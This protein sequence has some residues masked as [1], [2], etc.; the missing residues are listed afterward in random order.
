[1]A[2]GISDP[3]KCTSTYREKDPPLDTNIIAGLFAS[4]QVGPSGDSRVNFDSIAQPNSDMTS[5]DGTRTPPSDAKP[6][7]VPTE[8][9]ETGLPGRGGPVTAAGLPKG[10]Q[11]PVT[12]NSIGMKLALIPGASSSRCGSPDANAPPEEL[13]EHK[14]RITTPFLLGVTEVT[15]AQ[16]EG[17]IG[18]NPSFFS[19]TGEG[20]DI[21]AGQPTGEYP[22]E[23]VSWLDAIAFCNAFSKKEGLAPYYLVN[24]ED[25]KIPNRKGPGYRL[26]T[27]AEWEYACRAGKSGKFPP[28]D[29]MIEYG[30]FR[31]NSNGSTHPVGKKRPNEF[32]LFDMHANVFEWCFDGFAFDYY[33]RSPADDPQGPDGMSTRVARGSGWRSPQRKTW[34]TRFEGR[35]PHQ[36]HF[37]VGFRVARTQSAIAVSDKL[38][39]PDAAAATSAKSLVGQAPSASVDKT[40]INEPLVAT[41]IHP[42]AT[43][44]VKGSPEEKLATRGLARS[45]A[46]FVVASEA[47]ILEKFQKIKPLIAGLAQ[48]FNAFAVALRNE[49]LLADA[50]AYYTDIKERVDAAYDFV[51][52]MPNGSRASSQDKQ[53]YQ[54]AQMA[55]NELVQERDDSSK[56]VDAMRTQQV[57][58]VRKEELIK[59]FNAKWSEFRKAADELMPLIDKALGEYRKLH[60]DSTVRDALA[61]LSRSTKAAAILGPSKNLQ[62]SIDTIKNARRTYSPETAAPKKKARSSG[63]SPAAAQKRKGQATKQ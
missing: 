36:R 35:D 27:E 43:P 56:V 42:L 21:V 8:T 50:E 40:Q 28:G 30:W 58:A 38:S 29:P 18:K 63:A 32:G 13:P 22:V 33:Q 62:N 52:K 14:V 44:F 47:E 49:W 5:D 61:T 12:E 53:E 10:R 60:G 45:G 25:V 16:Y 39:L 15:Q 4:R 7:R 24:G 6:D 51:S 17:V 34:W 31:D 59:A 3:F 23:Q 9:A 41:A 48:P 20:K 46:Y 19:P 55:L 26:P 57:P 37:V 1:M 54:T 11:P 2:A